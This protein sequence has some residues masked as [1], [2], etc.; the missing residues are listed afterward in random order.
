M[1]RAIL[2]FSLLALSVPAPVL[3]EDGDPDLLPAVY[4]DLPASGAALDAFVPQGWRLETTET[5]DLNGDGRDDAALTLRE[6]NPAGIIDGRPQ[7]GPERYDTNPRMLAVVFANT[8][9][10]YDLAL[11]NHTLV[12][13]TTEPSLQDPLDPD[14]IQE[15]GIAI[16]NGTLRVTLGYFA[17][18]MGNVTFTFRY[19]HNR[20]E[21]IG[22]DHVNVERNSGATTDVSIN[23]STR[24]V[25]TRTGNIGDDDEKVAL[26]K[27]PAAPLLTMPDIGDGLEFTPL[28]D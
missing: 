26:T 1:N 20:F 14:G 9:G 25:E 16:G 11:E 28:P 15:G 27:L 10:G 13:R 23:Y 12:G 19:Q 5:G 18:D 8:A 4:P 7:G 21:L 22:Y 24:R 6:D 3:A 2:T 17:G